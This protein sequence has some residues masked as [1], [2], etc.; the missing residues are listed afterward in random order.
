MLREASIAR[1]Y[2][3]FIAESASSS[4]FPS[5]LKFSQTTEGIQKPVDTSISEDLQAKNLSTEQ[6][7]AGMLGI[8]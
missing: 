6:I 5:L 8:S 2:G 1:L 3:T 4:V 7:K